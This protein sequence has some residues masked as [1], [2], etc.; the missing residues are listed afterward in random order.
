MPGRGVQPALRPTGRGALL[1]GGGRR[2]AGS[3]ARERASARQRR[4]SPL[5]A[6]RG[7]VRRAGPAPDTGGREAGRASA[8]VRVRVSA[9]GEAE[10]V[11]VSFSL[12]Q[13]KA[14]NQQKKKRKSLV[15][16][17]GPLCCLGLHVVGG[18]AGVSG[19]VGSVTLYCGEGPRCPGA[20][21]NTGEAES[22]G[23]LIHHL[24]P[25]EGRVQMETAT[26]GRAGAFAALAGAPQVLSS[27]RG[28][29]VTGHLARVLPV[30]VHR[31]QP[32]FLK[33][34]PT[35]PGVLHWNYL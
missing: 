24:F 30:H 35:P 26:G 22:L 20:P 15:T 31:L 7:C 28:G 2:A 33:T 18:G 21:P 23:G 4:R 1:P 25:G 5:C 3:C 14:C 19:G 11:S 12:R 13:K 9:G 8:C 32:K 16:V 27:G 17:A 10:G 34:P 29:L 6:A